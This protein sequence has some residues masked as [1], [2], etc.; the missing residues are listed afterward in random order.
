[1]EISQSYKSTV[2]VR[3]SGGN[4]IY[5]FRDR[6][7]VVKAVVTTDQVPKDDVPSSETWVQLTVR[8]YCRIHQW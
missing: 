8:E 2:Y 5:P 1:M 4:V 3:L 7:K 6:S